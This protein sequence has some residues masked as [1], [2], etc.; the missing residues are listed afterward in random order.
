MYIFNSSLENNEIVSHNV[1][2]AA[3][4]FAERVVIIVIAV[5]SKLIIKAET[6]KYIQVQWV[7]AFVIII[8]KSLI[9]FFVCLVKTPLIY[10]GVDIFQEIINIILLKSL[11]NIN[12]MII[13]I[14]GIYGVCLC[15]D[16]DITPSAKQINKSVYFFGKTFL[17]G[18]YDSIFVSDII[19][20][21]FN[22]HIN[23]SLR[24]IIVLSTQTHYWGFCFYIAYNYTRTA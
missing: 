6:H 11:H 13:Y 24:N 22:S 9:A 2:K 4:V 21:S 19:K 5:K 20:W 15:I 12:D 17:N 16:A 8:T 1:I 23:A 14:I 18:V 7:F 3:S 10:C